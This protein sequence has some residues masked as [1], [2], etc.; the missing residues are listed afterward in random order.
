LPRTKINL[1]APGLPQQTGTWQKIT[2]DE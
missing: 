2:D 1:S